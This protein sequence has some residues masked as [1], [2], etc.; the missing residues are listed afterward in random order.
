MGMWTSLTTY[1]LRTEG[2]RVESQRSVSRVRGP[3]GGA[4][5]PPMIA[6][7]IATA[8]QICRYSVR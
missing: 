3:G 2:S 8:R 7:P 4:H 1:P 5:M 6:N